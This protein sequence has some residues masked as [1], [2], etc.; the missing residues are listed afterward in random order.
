MA[1]SIDTEIDVAHLAN[2][3]R[4]SLDTQELQGIHQD[5]T[6]I[7]Q[8]INQMQS[9]NTESV[10]PMANPLDATQRLRQDIISE[11]VDVKNFQAH[12]PDTS[13]DYYLVPRV[14]E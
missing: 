4:L 5:L 6:N 14:V 13:D 8:M 12:A 9:I 11:Q 7:M 1:N 3:A 10:A 2:L